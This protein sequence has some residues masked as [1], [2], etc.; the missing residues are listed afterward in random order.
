VFNHDLLMRRHT[1][2]LQ[3]VGYKRPHHIVWDRSLLTCL[4]LVSRMLR[5]RSVK[6]CGKILG[7]F[8]LEW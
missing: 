6:W 7:V 2:L 3:G 5:I 1:F 8:P 4:I